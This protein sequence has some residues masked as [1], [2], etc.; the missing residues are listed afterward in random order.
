MEKT[1]IEWVNSGDEWYV[2]GNDKYS[3]VKLAEDKFR[4][5]TG[6]FFES[7]TKTTLEDAKKY[8]EGLI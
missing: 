1:K 6:C 8:V 3:I 5:T 7:A 4:V 2:L